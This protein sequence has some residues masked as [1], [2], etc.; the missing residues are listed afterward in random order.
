MKYD[1]DTQEHW[2]CE[3]LS[4]KQTNTGNLTSVA[5]EAGCAPSTLVLWTK[6]FQR[7]MQAWYDTW[8]K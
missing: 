6:A 1:K 2:A 5:K 7:K 8:N 3:Y 4:A